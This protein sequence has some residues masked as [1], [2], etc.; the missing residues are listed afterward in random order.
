MTD[1]FTAYTADY[2]PADVADL[3]AAL[4]DLVLKAARRPHFWTPSTPEELA[5]ADKRV[6]ACVAEMIG[7]K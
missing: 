1:W 2:T 3:G 6:K 5:E 4:G 7:G